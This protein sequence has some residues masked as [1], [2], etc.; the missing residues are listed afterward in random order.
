MSAVWF[1]EIIIMFMNIIV[2]TNEVS[3]TNQCL[4]VLLMLVNMPT[5]HVTAL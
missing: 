4:Y 3:M 5:L 2:M 1:V